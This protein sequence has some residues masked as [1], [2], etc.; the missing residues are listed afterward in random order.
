M[1]RAAVIALIAACGQDARSPTEAADQGSAPAAVG[2]NHPHAAPNEVLI[3]AT[4]FDMGP[5]DPIT[6]PQVTVMRQHAQLG[7]F[8]IDRDPATNAEYRAC[9]DAGAC[10][11][12]CKAKHVCTGA[13]YDEIE[14]ADADAATYPVATATWDGARAYCLWAGKRLPTEDEWERAARGASLS[15]ARERTLAQASNEVDRPSRWSKAWLPRVG[16]HTADAT[17]EGVRYMLTGVPELVARAGG[18]MFAAQSP[19]VRGN[20]SWGGRVST[21]FTRLGFN[22]PYPAWAR[23]E[24]AY[25]GFRCARSDDPNSPSP[26]FFSDRQRLLGGREAAR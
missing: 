13:M 17:D 8:Y 21:T 11:P 15:N 16:V 6:D 9:M 23:D 25:G 19:V 14:A 24:G 18:G 2:N 5:V 10:P 26:K 3:A 20:L 12:D 4:E 1:R 22:Y 7:A